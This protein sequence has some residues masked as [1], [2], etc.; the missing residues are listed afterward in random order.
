MYKYFKLLLNLLEQKK[1]KKLLSIFMKF[2][3]SSLKT[4]SK[5]KCSVVT[6]SFQVELIKG[7]WSTRNLC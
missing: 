5:K 4:L 7:I 1:P 6:K 3:N 2:F